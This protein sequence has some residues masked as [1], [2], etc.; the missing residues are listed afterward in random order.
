M[1]PTKA[2]KVLCV[3]YVAIAAFALVAT[4]RNGGPYI[5]NPVDLFVKFWPDTKA[6]AASRFA[7]ADLVMLAITA[8]V[9]ML[10][11]GRRQRVRLVWAY[12]VGGILIAMSAAFPLFLIAREL[13]IGA[14]EGPPSRGRVDPVR[15]SRHCVRMPDDLGRV[16]VVDQALDCR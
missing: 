1:A 7:A 6:T 4:W 5:H 12:I 9:F 10:I 3:V 2:G 15:C 14:S 11:E 13:R 8:G 16:A